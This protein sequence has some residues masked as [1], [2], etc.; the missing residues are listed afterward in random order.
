MKEKALPY[1]KATRLDKLNKIV[2]NETEYLP[3]F[4]QYLIRK[5]EDIGRA[6]S[7]ARLLDILREID[8]AVSTIEKEFRE[9]SKLRV[10]KG[11]EIGQLA[12]SLSA[13]ILDDTD[14]VKPIAGI[15]GCTHLTDIFDELMSYM[16]EKIYVKRSDCYV[17]YLLKTDNN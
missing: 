9:L 10:L 2:K 5:L 12:V 13:L 4:S 1:F 11:Q 6:D 14:T 15:L 8:Y 3:K 7:F 17:P 16:G